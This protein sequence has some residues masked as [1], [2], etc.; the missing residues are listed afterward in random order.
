MYPLQM[1]DIWDQPIDKIAID[2]I[3]GLNVSI[4]ENHH[5]LTIIAILQDGQ[6]HFLSPTK[7]Q[8]LLLYFC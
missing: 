3:R 7:R 4:S 6:K 5:I 1:M 2:L 8:T